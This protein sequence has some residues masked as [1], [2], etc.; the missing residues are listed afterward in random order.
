MCVNKLKHSLRW[1]LPG[2]FF[3]LIIA[4]S[5]IHGT[6]IAHRTVFHGNTHLRLGVPPALDGSSPAVPK[7]A[8]YVE[9]KGRCRNSKDAHVLM[10]SVWSELVCVHSACMHDLLRVSARSSKKLS[11]V[12]EVAG[13]AQKM[14]QKI[15]YLTLHGL[16]FIF[17]GL[18]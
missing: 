5:L 14:D 2:P 13:S 9:R 8:G 6:P 7:R 18:K 17:M 16:R 4:G 12:A 3:A 10:R 15:L 11:S 1:L